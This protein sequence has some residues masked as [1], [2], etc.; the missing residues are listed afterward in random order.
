MEL[1][2]IE[3]AI[4]VKRDIEDTIQ[5]VVPEFNHEGQFMRCSGWAS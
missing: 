1:F 5:R 4:E 3:S 2:R